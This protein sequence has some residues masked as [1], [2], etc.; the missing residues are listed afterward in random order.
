MGLGKLQKRFA[1]FQGGNLDMYIVK[2]PFL[3][4][5]RKYEPYDVL[6]DV[7]IIPT[8]NLRSMLNIGMLLHVPTQE[9]LLIDLEQQKKAAAK[10]KPKR[11]PRNKNKG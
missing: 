1:F 11:P 5:N 3:L 2:K 9:E 4:G 7:S 6:E 10:P 8:R